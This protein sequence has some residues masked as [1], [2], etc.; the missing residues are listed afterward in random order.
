MKMK[1]RDTLI[2]TNTILI[3]TTAAVIITIFFTGTRSAV[4]SIAN[5][6]MGEIL[7]SVKNEAKITFQKAEN[8]NNEI[9][10]RY[11]DNDW[12]NI[13][14]DSER[15]FDYF[16]QMIKNNDTFTSVYV[17]DTDGKMIMQ[18]RMPDNRGHGSPHRARYQQ[19]I[20]SQRELHCRSRYGQE[21][22]IPLKR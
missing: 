17:A 1:I 14:N 9:A 16:L 18:Q 5:Q 6:L 15:E 10:T 19:E 3:I 12:D 21:V 11:W 13:W 20:L 7:N 8:A 4:Y 2:I 22:C